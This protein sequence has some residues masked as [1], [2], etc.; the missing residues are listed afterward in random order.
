MAVLEATYRVIL[1]M[2]LRVNS[3]VTSGASCGVT[4]RALR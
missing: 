3:R 4:F 2:T 1:S